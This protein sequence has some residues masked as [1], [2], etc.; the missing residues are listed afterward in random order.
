M[1]VVIITPEQ[2][3]IRELAV[4]MTFRRP[5]PDLKRVIDGR[6]VRKL[7]DPVAF[8]GAEQP[9]DPRKLRHL[10]EGKDARDVKVV[11]TETKIIVDDQVTLDSELYVVQTAEFWREGDFHEVTMLR[12]RGTIA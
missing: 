1:A 10:P 12:Q 2:E 6:T 7:D 11:W 9:F 3:A 4:P 5:R 8:E